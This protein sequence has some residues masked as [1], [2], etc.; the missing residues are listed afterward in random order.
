MSGVCDLLTA[1]Q[2]P[3]LHLTGSNSKFLWKWQPTCLLLPTLSG[4]QWVI[5]Q[6]KLTIWR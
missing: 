5:C 3:N 2:E 4:K 6:A 1:Y